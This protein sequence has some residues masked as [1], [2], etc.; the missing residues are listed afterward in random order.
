MGFLDKVRTATEQAIE[1]GKE[2][3]EEQKTKRELN[4]AFGDL[5]ETV[6]DL[7]DSG[8]LTHDR[9]TEG[10]E[11]IRSLKAKLATLEESGGSEPAE[12]EEPAST[13]PSG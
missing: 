13:A 9:L 12:A 6:F 2:E 10:V 8:A 11:R 7:V 1:R 3:L 5:G 4:Q